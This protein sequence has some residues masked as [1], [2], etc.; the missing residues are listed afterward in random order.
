[1]DGKFPNFVAATNRKHWLDGVWFIFVKQG[2]PGWGRNRK[3][4]ESDKKDKKGPILFFSTRYSS[5]NAQ[6]K[7]PLIANA[8][9]LRVVAATK[10]GNRQSKMATSNH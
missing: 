8:S 4:K 3:T 10:V 7:E 1:M 5:L 9:P 6:R 2:V